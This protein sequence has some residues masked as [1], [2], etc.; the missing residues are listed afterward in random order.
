MRKELTHASPGKQM[1]DQPWIDLERV[2][3]VE[4]TSEDAAH[5][6]EAALVPG[7]ET[8]WRAAVPGD[9]TIRIIFD[10]PLRL[11]RVLLRFVERIQPQIDGGR[12]PIKRVVG[13]WVSV[14]ANVFADGHD[15][16]E[17][18]LLYRRE[19]DAN[20]SETPMRALGNDRWRA[21]F[22]VTEMGRYRYTL[23]GWIS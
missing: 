22:Q 12:F 8:G 11:R 10:Q 13:D 18:R 7:S 23:E 16:V 1:P 2:T 15:Q 6:I 4:L 14:E 17:C 5:P 20:W 21:E 19:A 3:R 9:Q